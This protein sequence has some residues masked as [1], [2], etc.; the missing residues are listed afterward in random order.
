MYNSKHK[1]KL[2][3]QEKADKTVYSHVYFS[4]KNKNVQAGLEMFDS[5]RASAMEAAYDWGYARAVWYN[6]WTWSNT[7][8][9][10]K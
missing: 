8:W 5:T 4:W 2:T 10:T 1:L 9:F 7:A 3:P 6:P